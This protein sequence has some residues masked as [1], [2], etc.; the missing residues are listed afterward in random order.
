MERQSEERSP[1][2]WAPPRGSHSY[3]SASSSSSDNEA[4]PSTLKLKENQQARH[5]DKRT[6]EEEPRVPDKR[7]LGDPKA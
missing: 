6:Q 1:P 2:A 5:L 7:T 3:G 4:G